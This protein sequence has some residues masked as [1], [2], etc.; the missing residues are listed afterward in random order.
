MTKQ[1]IET[2][3]DEMK[4]IG[5]EWT[6]EQVT[7]VYG[8]RSLADALSDRKSIIGKFADNINKIINS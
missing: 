3:I 2:F 6:E 7:D 8:N 1:E 4:T 5:D